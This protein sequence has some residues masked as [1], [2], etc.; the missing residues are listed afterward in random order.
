[1]NNIKHKKISFFLGALYGGGAQRVMVI[2]ATALAE[3]DI[4]VDLVL[5]DASGPYLKNVPA[6]VNI[7]NLASGRVIR[8]I[9]RL[10]SYLR[11]ERPFAMLSTVAHANVAALLAK[12][13]SGVSTRL[14]VRVENTISQSSVDATG[15]RS[16]LLKN[17]IRIC[18]PGADGVVAP[19]Q[20]VADDLVKNIH[21][22]KQL[23]HVIY[24]PVVR[25]E[26]MCEAKKK[27]SHPWF[28]PG[29]PPVVLGVGRLTMQK[30]FITLINAFYLVRKTQSVHLIILGEGEARPELEKRIKILKLE[31]DVALPGFVNNPYAYMAQSSVFVLSSLWE[32]L[33]NTLIEALAVGM[34]VIATDCES[35]PREI[36]QQGKYGLLVSIKDEKAIA[37]G[38]TDVVSGNK[39][40]MPDREALKEYN[41]D[42]IIGKYAKLLLNE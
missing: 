33:P 5:A 20:G 21:I 38:I 24:N 29:S 30:D 16:F 4:L 34:P 6:N 9:P 42:I 37:A 41:R 25:P 40:P 18:Y 17:L 32:G 28:E 27:I 10:V 2:L 23:I 26:I 15:F 35:G 7:V 22:P 3:K 39:F 12:R 31:N 19:S 13:I 8:S 36:L 11:K 1:M 14:F